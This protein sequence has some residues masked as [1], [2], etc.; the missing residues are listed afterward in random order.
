MLISQNIRF[1]FEMSKPLQVVICIFA[2]VCIN[3]IEC[4]KLTKEN[5]NSMGGVHFNY[6]KKQITEI[7][8]AALELIK[9]TTFYVRFNNFPLYS[10]FLFHLLILNSMQYNITYVLISI[11]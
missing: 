6:Y 3:R 1:F 2:I 9:S 11:Y 10:S 7:N 8:P 4:V 5:V